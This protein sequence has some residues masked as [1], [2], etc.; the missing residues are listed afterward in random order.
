MIHLYQYCLASGSLITESLFGD[1]AMTKN[2]VL[3]RKM[4]AICELKAEHMVGSQD[5]LAYLRAVTRYQAICDQISHNKTVGL[6]LTPRDVALLEADII[7]LAWHW[8]KIT[9]IKL[10]TLDNYWMV[11][12]F[13]HCVYHPHNQSG[14]YSTYYWDIDLL[15]A[16]NLILSGMVELPGRKALFESM[17]FRVCLEQIYTLKS[18]GERFSGKQILDD[19]KFHPQPD[20]SS[21][22]GELQFLLTQNDDGDFVAEIEELRLAY[23]AGDMPRCFEICQHIK[24][25]KAVEDIRL[26]IRDDYPANRLM[27]TAAETEYL[28]NTRKLEERAGRELTL[29]RL[30]VERKVAIGFVYLAMDIY[31]HLSVEDLINQVIANK[32]RIMINSMASM[33]KNTQDGIHWLA[34]E[35]RRLAEDVRYSYM[36]VLQNRKWLE[37][38]FSS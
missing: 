34:K 25:Q 32:R 7:W 13:V 19:P 22:L 31:P 29:G 6:K 1:I 12:D 28:F 36:C 16:L 27:L 38:Y 30:E 23:Q 14:D 3:Y 5:A 33:R 18:T 4:E 17:F 11:P 21:F 10:N 35:N 24:L 9:T 2:K 15:H 37:R 26:W 8:L 20:D